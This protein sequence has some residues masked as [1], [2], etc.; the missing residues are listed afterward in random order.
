MVQNTTKKPLKNY[1]CICLNVVS[2]DCL[3]RNRAGHSKG[4]RGRER[5]EES[6]ERRERDE[7]KGRETEKNR[8][9]KTV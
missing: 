2:P 4:W 6:K 7:E 3:Q 8:G 9:R 1:Q 5:I